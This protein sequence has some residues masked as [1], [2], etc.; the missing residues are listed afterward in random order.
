MPAPKLQASPWTILQIL[1]SEQRGASI[2]S[3][4]RKYNV[5]TATIYRWKHRYSHE[6][7][8][9]FLQYA[10][11]DLAEVHNVVTQLSD[12]LASTMAQLEALKTRVGLKPIGSSYAK[13]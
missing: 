2:P 7:E 4:A 1:R 5:G 11:E 13:R 10:R 6:A 9:A 8:L 12:Q 3:L